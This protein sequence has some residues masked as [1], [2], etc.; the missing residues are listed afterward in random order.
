MGKAVVQI[1]YTKYVLEAK[2][3]LAIL[4]SI[5][6]AEIYESKYKSSAEGGTTYHV[7]PQAPDDNSN[8][9]I[10]LLNEN[11][12]RIAKLAGKPEQRS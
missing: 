12:Y 3:A 9:S 11:T 7:Y 1:G 2:D 8:L 6:N 4:E 5:Q 10:Q